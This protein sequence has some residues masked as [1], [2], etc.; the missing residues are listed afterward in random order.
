[1]LIEYAI[2]GILIYV[3]KLDTPLL[4]KFNRSGAD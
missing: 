2:E 4:M 3:L 1:M